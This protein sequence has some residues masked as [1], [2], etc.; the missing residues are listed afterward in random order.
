MT[1]CNRRKIQNVSEKHAYGR[2]M[3]DAADRRAS[4]VRIVSVMLFILLLIGLLSLL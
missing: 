2:K 3:L 4:F 1:P